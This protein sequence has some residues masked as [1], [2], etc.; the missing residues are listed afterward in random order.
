MLHWEIDSLADVLTL[1]GMFVV[2]IGG[3]VLAIRSRNIKIKTRSGEIST[4]SL[5]EDSVEGTCSESIQVVHAKIMADLK[6]GQDEIMALLLKAVERIN[7]TDESQG[8]LITQA[9][10]MQKFVRRE[11]GKVREDS[12][13]IN[14]D[15]DE[16]DEEI[17][18][19]QEI[20]RKGRKLS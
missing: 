2:L 10:I 9:A 6:K 3:I 14:G 19:A 7:S 4:A 12:D 16:A 18:R 13:I 5:G 20:Y 15:L 17:H 8:A 11:L 1:L